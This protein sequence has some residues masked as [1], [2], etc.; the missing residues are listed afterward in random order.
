MAELEIHSKGI[1]KLE[2]IICAWRM[3]GESGVRRKAI[4]WWIWILGIDLFLIATT[5]VKQYPLSFPGKR[6]LVRHFNLAVE[7]NAAVWWSALCLLALGLLAY[8]LYSQKKGNKEKFAWLALSAV[9]TCLSLD[10]LGSIHERIGGWSDLL[11]YGVV[12]GS[13]VACALA[14]LFRNPQTR[15]SSLFIGVG[16]SLFGSVA[17]Q[18]YLEHAGSWANWALG[19]RVALEE[20]S[21]L[22][23]ML[24]I[25]SGIV[26]HRAQ[27]MTSSLRAI[28][29]DPGRMKKVSE[30]VLIGG[31]LHIL[32]SMTV[33][34]LINVTEQGNPLAWYPVSVFFILLA[35]TL[36]YSDAPAAKPKML[37]V[38]S[39]FFLLCSA[40][41]AYDPPRLLPVIGSLVSR[42]YLTGTFLFSL[43]ALLLLI[44]AVIPGFWDRNCRYLPLLLLLPLMEFLDARPEIRSLSTGITA[45]LV[46]TIYRRYQ[47]NAADKNQKPES[48]FPAEISSDSAVKPA[49]ARKTVPTAEDRSAAFGHRK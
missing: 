24:L 38:L 8:E 3:P 48:S 13:L 47:R 40:G 11:P 44:G 45:L 43:S 42:E 12:F 18:E 26:P 33:P 5:A 34:G 21:E 25:F 35:W 1:R 17:L 46:F 49:A 14:V 7:M 10:E 20:G 2:R 39:L 9:F 23:G 6:W 28:I 30:I 19:L 15:R 4:P 36:E 29:P 32:A 31:G 27:G 16:I 41:L 22:L 37:P